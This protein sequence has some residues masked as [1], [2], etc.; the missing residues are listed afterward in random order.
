MKGLKEFVFLCIEEG[1][2][3]ESSEREKSA[4]RE[5]TEREIAR[6]GNT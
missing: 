1:N 5:E 3:R 6:E 2:K 4:K